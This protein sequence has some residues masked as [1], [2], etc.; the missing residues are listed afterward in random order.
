MNTR[1]AASVV[2]FSLVLPTTVQADESPLYGGLK[3]GAMLADKMNLG[4]GVTMSNP[5]GVA[6][7][8]VI[9]GYQSKIGKL[10]FL[11]AE[12]ELTTTFG[13]GRADFSRNDTKVP[14]ADN[15]WGV[16]TAALYGV[17]QSPG[18][19]YAK[20]RAGILY[21]RISA[22]GN[23][24]SASTTDWHGS[25][26]LGAGWK[27]GEGALELE[28]TVIEKNIDFVSLGYRFQIGN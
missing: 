1:I 27:I 11:G 9:G 21:D 8:G 6:N 23:A 2:L 12:G 16:T 14:Q 13:R 10:G 19:F 5:D 15:V 17:Y 20:A 24:L 22:S 26:G 18:K 4:D 28:Y 7:A 25:Y 3:V